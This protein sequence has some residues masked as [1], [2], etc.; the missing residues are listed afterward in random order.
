M[1]QLHTL[2]YTETKIH[3]SVNIFR[4]FAK[5]YSKYSKNKFSPISQRC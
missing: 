3:L 1:V 5:K 2:P 4:L